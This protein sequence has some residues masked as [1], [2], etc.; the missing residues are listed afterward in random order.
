MTSVPLI[1]KPNQS[2]SKNCLIR[3]TIYPKNKN[4]LHCHACNCKKITLLQMAMVQK[5]LMLLN[6]TCTMTL[7]S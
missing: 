4:Q 7:V 5:F 2:P 6:H 1:I 3:P